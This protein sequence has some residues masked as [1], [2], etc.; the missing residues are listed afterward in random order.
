MKTAKKALL[1]LVIVAMLI[2]MALTGCSGGKDNQII[3]GSTTALSGDWGF[4]QWTNNASDKTIRDLIDGY[5]PI[6]M[7][8][9]G[10]FVMD[11]NV[12][13][14]Y[15]SVVNA[16]GT[17]TFTVVLQE[18]LVW[19]DGK[20]VTAKDYVA[21]VLLFSSDVIVELDATGVAGMNFVGYE[22]YK[23]DSSVPFAGVR[24]LGDYSYAL[25]VSTDYLPYYFDTLYANIAPLPRQM[26]LPADI[27]V[28][29]DGQGA[30]FTGEFTK[31]HCGETIVTARNL[32]EGRVSCGPYV[33]E[34]FDATSKQATVVINPK[35]KGIWV[36]EARPCVKPSIEKIILV[37]SKQET[38][39]NALK[40]GAV[41]MLNELGEGAEIKAAMELVDAGGFSF[42]KYERNGYGKLM[43]QCDFGP[44]QFKSVRQAVAH[45][46]DRDAFADAFCGGYGAVVH[47]PY[48]FAMWMYKESE[49]ELNEK[50][51]TY[52]YGL[53]NAIAVLEA[54]G[55]NL[56]KD[57]NA[58]TSGI[59]YKKVTA[60]EAGD[61][62]HNVTLANGDILMPLIIEWLSS[63]G[64]S[65]SEMLS[66][67]LANADIVP[68]AGMKINQ[69]IVAWGEL[70]NYMYRDASVGE[71]YAV[72]TYGMYNLATGFTATYDMSFNYTLDPEGIALGWNT[73][74][75]FDEQLDQL[76]M[77]MVY[78]VEAG[79]TEGY[80]AKWVEFIDLWNE[81]LPEV[82]LYSNIYHSVYVDKLIDY[83][84][85]PMWDF[86]Y[87]I[88]CAKIK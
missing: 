38:Q 28:K 73:N 6:T 81:L 41:D 84:P 39:I 67:R 14:S 66:V 32:S 34:S 63:E 26:W 33:L 1:F 37:E 70:L 24:L 61:Y 75:I 62:V 77:D 78:G 3:V 12:A 53:E 27:D 83:N 60:E 22:E 36:D 21:Y 72:K 35:F 15:E 55:W 16:D 5:A 31:E 57:G 64:N 65:V 40:T 30:Y 58:Y 10:S 17:K 52:T 19:S 82:P 42:S 2:P 88:I 45:L 43:F 51:N 47:G 80:R 9:D 74:F 50:L 20:P 11:P 49:A 4:A 29:D 23:A 87:A 56:D 79:D 8:P 18:D 85:N 48:G 69:T 54:D 68:Q 25:T 86:G 76:S 7:E 44:T 71:K 59:R 13:K 46:L